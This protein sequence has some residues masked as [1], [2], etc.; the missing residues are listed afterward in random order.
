MDN[1]QSEQA[2]ERRILNESGAR[3]GKSFVTLAACSV[4]MVLAAQVRADDVAWAAGGPASVDSAPDGAM[5]PIAA[6]IEQ[7]LALRSAAADETTALLY[8]GRG[9]R[10]LWGD[11]ER[12]SALLS[13]VEQAATHG[14]DPQDFRPQRLRMLRAVPDDP[15]ERAKRLRE[16]DRRYGGKLFTGLCKR[17]GLLVPRRG[18]G[19]RFTL[20]ERLLRL[21]VVTTVPAGGR[22]QYD[23]FKQLLEARHGFVFDADGLNRAAAWANGAAPVNLGNGVDGWLQEMLAAAGLLVELSDSCSLVINPAQN[24]GGAA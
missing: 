7:R 8:L 9:Y 20:D 4:L 21:L 11:P 6:L 22:L 12:A 14:L 10:P 17:I 3:L 5:D 24:K 15:V 16:A 2:L 1:K 19:A 18:A 13:A 23:T